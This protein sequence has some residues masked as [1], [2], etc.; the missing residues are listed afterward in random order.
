VSEAAD[1]TARLLRNRVGDTVAVMRR[2]LAVTAAVLAALVGEWLGHGVAYYRVAG[3]AGLQA[4]LSGGV[5]DYMLPLGFALLLGAAAG[6]TAWTRAWLALGRRLERSGALL[7]RLRRGSGLD[8]APAEI[9]AASPTPTPSFPARVLALGLPLALVQSS[10]YAV[11]ENLERAVHGLPATGIR[12]LLDG[13]GAATW[14]QSAVALLLATVLVLALRLLRSRAAAAHLCERLVR[15][16]WERARR[17]TSSPR[18]RASFVT[19]VGLLL[20]SSTW[21]RPPPPPA[22]A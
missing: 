10:L 15:A 19:P 12:P 20:C 7:A 1:R 22:P 14:I 11:Q 9:K 21:Q 5:H 17:T 4:G 13:F 16:L 2:R 18:P 3:I 8:G 6:A